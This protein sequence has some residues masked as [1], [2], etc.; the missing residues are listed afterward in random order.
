MAGNRLRF[1]NEIQKANDFVWDE[2][3]DDAIASYRRALNEFPNDVATLMGYAWAL[4][5][6]E[7]LDEALVNY[8]RLTALNGA[9]PGPYERIAEIHQ[10][11]GDSEQAAEMYYEAAIRYGKQDLTTR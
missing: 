9:D 5:N 6:V 4:L 2:K 11:Q 3:W 7:E 10:R 1:D 8:K